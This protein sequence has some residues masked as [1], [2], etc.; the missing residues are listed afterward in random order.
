MSWDCL[1]SNYKLSSVNFNDSPC[2]LSPSHFWILFIFQPPPVEYDYIA[3]ADSKDA[4]G[5]YS[6]LYDK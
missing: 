5:D 4:N 6:Q 3:E 1:F 2:W